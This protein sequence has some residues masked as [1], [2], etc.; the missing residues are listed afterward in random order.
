VQQNMLIGAFS[1]D[2]FVGARQELSRIVRPSV[3]IRR[4]GYLRWNIIELNSV[5]WLPQGSAG[6]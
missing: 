6:P 2:D 5:I 4:P 1:L 3:G